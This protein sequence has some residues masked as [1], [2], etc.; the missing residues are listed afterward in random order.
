MR[1]FE[2]KDHQGNACK[3]TKLYKEKHLYLTLANLGVK[4]VE[5]RAL[6][7][8]NLTVDRCFW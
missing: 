2:R 4:M 8:P 6:G 5:Q 1:P 7:L 3:D